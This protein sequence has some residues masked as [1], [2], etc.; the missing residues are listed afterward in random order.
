MARTGLRSVTSMSSKL[1]SREVKRLPAPGTEVTVISPSVLLVSAPL[2][3]VS[4]I[5]NLK[6]KTLKF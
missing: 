6:E 1:A 2:V 3:C 4:I 5:L